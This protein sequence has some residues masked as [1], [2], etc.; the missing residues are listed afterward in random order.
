MEKKTL[1][2]NSQ[3]ILKQGKN[4]VLGRSG[5]KIVK[6]PLWPIYEMGESS[7]VH[8]FLRFDEVGPICNSNGQRTLNIAQ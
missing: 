3:Y 4:A 1:M 2:F 8:S 7:T 5:E 6:R